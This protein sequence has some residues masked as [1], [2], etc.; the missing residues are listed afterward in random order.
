MKNTKLKLIS[1]IIALL[2]IISTISCAV[3][4]QVDGVYQGIDDVTYAK[5]APIATIIIDKS[6]IENPENAKH[7]LLSN[8]PGFTFLT[9]EQLDAKT[10]TT[11]NSSDMYNSYFFVYDESVEGATKITGNTDS[12]NTFEGDIVSYTYDNAALL[13]NGTLGKVVI[14]YSNISIP[15]QSNFGQK[16]ESTQV[17]YEKPDTY[18]TGNFK[19]DYKPSDF[20]TY[21]SVTKRGEYL[22]DGVYAFG[23]GNRLNLWNNLI[24]DSYSGYT[25]RTG[26]KL[27][28][29]IQVLDNDGNIVDGLFFYSM[30]DIDLYRNLTSW[31]GQIYEANNQYNYSETIRVNSGIADGSALYI[32]GDLSDSKLYQYTDVF[33]DSE[34]TVFTAIKSDDDP[35]T[36]YSGFVTV[37][38][39]SKG[40]NLTYWGSC[41]SSSNL[42]TY[43]LRGS[44]FH[45]ISTTTTNGGTIKTTEKGNIDGTLNDNSTIIESSKFE[46]GDGKTVVY[47]VETKDGYSIDTMT[48]DNNDVT[49]P[50]VEGE[51][52]T[53]TLDGPNGEERTATI[54]N[55]GNGKFTVTFPENNYDHSLDVNWKTIE[56]PITYIL[57][58]GT[59]NEENPSSYTT[60]DEINIKDP[61]KEGYTF[62]GWNEGNQIPLGSTG[63]KTFTAKWK[64]IEEPAPG[65]NPEQPNPEQP[66]PEQP[67]PEPP[68]PEQPEPIVKPEKPNEVIKPNEKETNNP[69]TEDHINIYY[70]ILG[71]SLLGIYISSKLLKRKAAKHSK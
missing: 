37:V 6:I 32:P 28:I 45:T 1:C 27:D 19:G 33:N 50:S 39:N 10:Y 17:V 11:D 43:I 26:L 12:M 44:H 29:K 31:S 23:Y 57:D 55:I 21:N 71:T 35:G 69:K 54:K 15:M 25:T 20:W 70:T 52:T 38:D 5:V 4:I 7:K 40:L 67:V 46:L 49:I 51:E 41:S 14:T 60:E 56:Y 42:N 24:R 68:S 9:Q 65:G 34:G 47:T 2:L 36:T 18:I 59:N 66:N 8:H 53:I 30:T 3:E 48:I 58:G 13:P 62:L 64:K 63:A 22:F 61:T 16:G